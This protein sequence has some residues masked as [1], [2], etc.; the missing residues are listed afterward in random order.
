MFFTV[1]FYTPRSNCKLLTFFNCKSYES[2][3]Q[4]TNRH[5]TT[6][7]QHSQLGKVQKCSG[8]NVQRWQEREPET[9]S[10]TKLNQWPSTTTKLEWSW[11]AFES[12]LRNRDI[13]LC[14]KKWGKCIYIVQCQLHNLNCHGS[15]L[16]LIGGLYIFR[17]K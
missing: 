11:E 9:S 1:L 12:E 17:L 3:P 13:A 4:T 8:F 2:Y 6:L 5:L 14:F 10:L 15:S 16:V 7:K